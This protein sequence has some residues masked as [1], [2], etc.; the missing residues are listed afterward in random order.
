M[1]KIIIPMIIFLAAKACLAQSPIRYSMTLKADGRLKIEITEIRVESENVR[2]II[3]RSAPGTYE[4]TDYSLFIEDI[5]CFVSESDSVQGSKGL[6]SYFVFRTDEPISRIRY[7]V[8]LKKMEET[9]LGSFASSK[10]R[11]GYAGILG[12]S[13][14]GFCDG[15]ENNPISLTVVSVNDWPIFTTLD[16]IAGQ[17]SGPVHFEAEN[18]S[19]LVDAQYLLGGDVQIKEVRNSSIPLFAAVYSETKVDLDEVS[20]R[21]NKTLEV[22]ENY[23]G[24][25]PMPYYT[26]C[27]E[28]FVPR[29]NHHDYGFSMEHMNSMTASMDTSKAI[30]AYEPEANIG[31]WVHHMAHSW[32]PLRSYGVGYRPFE[33]QTAPIIETIWL[34]EGFIWYIMTQALNQPERMNYFKRVIRNAPDYIAA[35]SLKELSSLGSTQYSSDFDIGRNLFSRGALMA[36]EMDIEIQK[37]T[38]GEL[39]FKDALAGLMKWTEANRRGFTYDEIET[40]L[41]SS[42]DTDL[43]TIWT[44]WQGP[45]NND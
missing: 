3:P 28:Y 8:N 2:F 30:M 38:K 7:Q 24:F 43:S 5:Y 42:T 27:L 9:L 17:Q 39:S 18:Y 6:G 26:F 14:F 16:P 13:V 31:S 25:V 19:L 20:R 33:W 45:M 12:Y 37:N 34:N 41:S 36:A 44:K 22:L 11:S 4:I 23:F 29:S 15:Y 35:K 32:I 10:L 1:T 40:I 21:A